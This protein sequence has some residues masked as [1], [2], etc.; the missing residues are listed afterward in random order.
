M[1]RLN[2]DPYA[3]FHLFA[4]VNRVTAL[5][6]SEEAVT[7]T[8]QGARGGRRRDRRHRDLHR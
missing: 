1:A 3:G 8:V 7:A 4:L 6:E 5:L 2:C